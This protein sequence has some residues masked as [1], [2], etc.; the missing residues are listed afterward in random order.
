MSTN[1]TVSRTIRTERSLEEILEATEEVL[2]TLGGEISVNKDSGTISI[3]NGKTGITGDFLFDCSAK[4]RVKKKAE[5]KYIIKCYV[6]KSPSTIF[7]L[8]LIGG[9]CFLWY[10]WA[11]N[12][13]YL[14]I[15]LGKEYQKKLDMIEAHF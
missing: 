2:T 13:F 12:I 8:L 11:G 9:L 1:Y 10:I 15:D 14:F 6:E 5:G 7:W 3:L 4:V